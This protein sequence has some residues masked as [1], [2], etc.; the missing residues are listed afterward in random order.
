MSDE[1]NGPEETFH[2]TE[3]KLRE[4]IEAL[5][6]ER[7]LWRNECWMMREAWVEQKAALAAMT[8][9]REKWFSFYETWSDRAMSEASEHMET[10]ARLAECEAR[11][12]KAVEALDM[13]RSG[14][15]QP[16]PDAVTEYE[17]KVAQMKKDFP[18]GI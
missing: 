3:R 5:E 16:A 4:R 7:S 1:R 17:R 14:E 6:R 10:K 13:V 12:S 9:E 8:A 18:N 2:D 11:L 15:T